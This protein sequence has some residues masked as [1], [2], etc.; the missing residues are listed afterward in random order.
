MSEPI[1][2]TRKISK[3]FGNIQALN[4]VDISIHANSVLALCGDNGAGKSTLIK[5]IS[6]VYTPDSG[7]IFSFG[8]KISINSPRSAYELG[9]ETVYQDLALCE[10][11]N[12]IQNLF[13]GREKPFQGSWIANLFLDNKTM[14]KEA[15]KVFDILGT[16]IPSLSN[17]IST[18]S[19]GQRQ[20]VAIARAV[21]WGSK[22][23][24]LDEP[25][26]ALGVD[27]T[28]N[29]HK[30]IKN[31]RNQGVGVVLIT[32]NMEDV[33]ALADKV[34]VLRQGSKNAEMMVSDCTSDDVVKA[35]TGS[36]INDNNKNG[37]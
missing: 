30:I 24:I 26:A 12:V 25:T 6:G 13:L 19:G 15:K 29:V 7:E 18:L 4:S 17:Q 36:S 14:F 8:K 31:L 27:Q 11:L 37:K 28:E 9:I 22:L 34:I 33:F 2:E 21:V 20:A 10:N 3:R 5:I 16:T 35:I 23:V 32:H 1:L